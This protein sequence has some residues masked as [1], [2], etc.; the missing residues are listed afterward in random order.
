MT[1]L[2]LGILVSPQAGTAASACVVVL[3]MSAQADV[4]E[5]ETAETTVTVTGGITTVSGGRPC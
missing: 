2:I 1:L 3:A 4:V 5:T